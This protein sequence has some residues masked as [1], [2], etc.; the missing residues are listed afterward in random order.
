MSNKE[1]LVN[2]GKT[3]LDGSITNGQLTIDVLD[4]SV[5]PA[6][7]DFRII[8]DQEIMLV[9]NNSSNTLTVV[10]GQ[11]N[12]LAV[13]HSD[14][15]LV[16]QILTK[17]GLQRYLRDSIPMFD[18]PSETS[19][20]L[21]VFENAAGTTLTAA[22]FTWVNQGSSTAA[23][24]EAG[25][26]Y[27]YAPVGSSIN[28]RALVISQPSTPYTVTSALRFGVGADAYNSVTGGDSVGLCFRESATGKISTIG[29][30]GN[31]NI[32]SQDF[33]DATTFGAN[34]VVQSWQVNG[35]LWLQLEND[36][37]N[38]NFKYSIDG[39]SFLQL[40]TDLLATFFTT[41]P[42]QVGMFIHNGSNHSQSQGCWMSW[43]EE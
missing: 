24:Y 42:D 28:V 21:N 32:V 33:T 37:T 12:T 4:G 9:T 27:M 31:D 14:G 18:S 2:I 8:V 1:R 23:D 43:I 3:V 34:N 16:N 20:R 13:A 22:S 6:A 41:A 17:E 26:V 7:G 29:Y 38:L 11:E 10:R 36:G 5:L 35:P 40:H 30:R 19:N 39:I 15:A 25:G